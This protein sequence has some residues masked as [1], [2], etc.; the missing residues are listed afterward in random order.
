MSSWPAPPPFALRFFCPLPGRFIEKIC[1]NDG[2]PCSSSDD[3]LKKTNF[4]SVPENAAS[5]VP[6]ST[7]TLAPITAPT[8]ATRAN[9]PTRSRFISP[10]P[11][12]QS[13]S[14]R[15]A[16]R[17][18][19]PQTRSGRHRPIRELSAVWGRPAADAGTPPLEEECVAPHAVELAD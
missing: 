10:P 4:P 9:F 6:P 8:T 15:A 11:I 3:T 16:S 17:R 12:A 13:A 2:G 19:R 5:A 1:T 18:Q 7:A 14:S